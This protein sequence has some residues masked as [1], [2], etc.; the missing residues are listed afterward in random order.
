MNNYTCGRRDCWEAGHCLH[1]DANG[2][3]CWERPIIRDKD[4]E[5]ELREVLHRYG[6]TLAYLGR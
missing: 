2:K 5:T 6:K 3:F 1:Q 4:L